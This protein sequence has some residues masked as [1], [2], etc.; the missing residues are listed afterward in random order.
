MNDVN[1]YEKIRKVEYAAW[2]DV[3]EKKDVDNM[4]RDMKREKRKR[5]KEDNMNV[6]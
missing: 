2:K 4:R 5:F 6:W 3:V 1:Y